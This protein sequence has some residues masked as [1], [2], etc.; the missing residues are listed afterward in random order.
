MSTAGR[1]WVRDVNL[2]PGVLLDV[3]EEQVIVQ[4]RLQKKK[5]RH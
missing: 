5:K 3:V 1:R 4:V 2:G